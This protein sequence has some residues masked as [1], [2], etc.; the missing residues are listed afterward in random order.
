M[1]NL[2][3]K[4]L[5]YFFFL[6]LFLPSKVHS[7]NFKILAIVENSIITS[8]DLF[9]EIKM[10]EKIK[11]SEIKKNQYNLIL[12]QLIN[13][14][15]KSIE[16]SNHKL[17]V[18]LAEVD[19]RIDKLVPDD[20]FVE[21]RNRLKEKLLIEKKW[22]TLI[23]MKYKNNLKINMNEIDI[24]TNNKSNA[25]KENLIKLEIQKKFNSFSESYFNEIK[26]KYF[27][28]YTK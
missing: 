1:I 12:A 22:N 25:N 13:D 10:L 15:I 4:F 7:D 8:Y 11:G 2:S 3:N 14:Q 16:I 28:K 27:I 6:I 21:I 17:S 19:K 5:I 24:L 26:K 20:Q 18:N 9:I 23:N